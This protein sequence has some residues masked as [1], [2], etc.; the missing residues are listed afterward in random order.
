MTIE[1]PRKIALERIAAAYGVSSV[2][3]H[4]WKR[5][6][7][8]TADLLNPFT[9]APKLRASAVNDSP[10]LRL[11]EDKGT[12]GAITFRLAVAGLIKS[13]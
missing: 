10:R 4:D 11:L 13:N 3:L 7:I 6:G 9:L 1:A 2:T 8:T 5:R 12:L